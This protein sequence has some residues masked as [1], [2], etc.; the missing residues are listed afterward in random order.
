LKHHGLRVGLFER[1]E[2]SAAV[3]GGNRLRYQ[4]SDATERLERLELASFFK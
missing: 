4:V 3:N 2:Q 1:L